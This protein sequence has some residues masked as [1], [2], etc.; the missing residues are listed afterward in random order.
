MTPFDMQFSTVIYNERVQEATNPRHRNN[1]G[2]W[3][4]RTLPDFGEALTSLAQKVGM[5]SQ[6]KQARSTST[7]G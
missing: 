5:K 7:L 2:I 3:S 1:T 4:V 6:P